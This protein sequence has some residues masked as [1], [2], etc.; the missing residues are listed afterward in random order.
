MQISS[1]LPDALSEDGSGSTCSELRLW[2]R[3]R[4]KGSL[5]GGQED[6]SSLTVVRLA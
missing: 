5:A 4:E 2:L 1:K 6:A 3:E